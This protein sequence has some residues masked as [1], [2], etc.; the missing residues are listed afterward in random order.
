MKDEQ[1]KWAMGWRDV[2]ARKFNKEQEMKEEEK[3]EYEK[4]KEKEIAEKKE[5]I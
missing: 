2:E 3:E 1:D 4:A 5:T